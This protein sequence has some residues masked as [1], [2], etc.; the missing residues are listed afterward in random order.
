MSDR[1]LLMYVNVM[2]ITSNE[3]RNGSD[4]SGYS[5]SGTGTLKLMIS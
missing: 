2:R 5:G 1:L 4:R 3:T